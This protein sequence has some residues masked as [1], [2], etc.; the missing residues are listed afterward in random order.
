M[1]RKRTQRVVYNGG[2]YSYQGEAMA[3]PDRQMGNPFDEELPPHIQRRK[4]GSFQW[5][6]TLN[7]RREPHLLTLLLKMILVPSAVLF[8]GIVFYSAGSGVSL[9]NVIKGM[10]IIE[11]VIVLAALIIVF[12]Y[13]LMA[14]VLGDDNAL[15]YEMNDYGI[16][17]IPTGVSQAADM[18][19]SADVSFFRKVRTVRIDREHNLIALNSWFLYNLVYC[20]PEDFDFVVNHITERCTHALLL[21]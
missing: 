5:T 1:I 18:R 7:M 3:Q 4:D 20:E 16:R 10:W 11:A 17:L 14:K 9:L 21:K 6:Y 12:C 19:S 8:A 2:M 15:T 13:F